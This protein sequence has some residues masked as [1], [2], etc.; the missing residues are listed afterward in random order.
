MQKNKISSAFTLVEILL[1]IAIIGILAGAVYAMIGN[2]DNSKRKTVLTTAKSIMPYAQECSFKGDDL[3][4]A[5]RDSQNGGGVI[6]ADSV[7]IWPKIGVVGC[8]YSVIPVGGKK[9]AVDCSSVFDAG[10]AAYICCDAQA[11]SCV[12]STSACP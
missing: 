8:V 10:S 2:S 6:C 1:V 5:G 3:S 7:T 4:A 11:G 9:Y 12:E